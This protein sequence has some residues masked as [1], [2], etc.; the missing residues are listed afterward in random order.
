M[1]TVIRSSQECPMAHRYA[2]DVAAALGRDLHVHAV[3]QNGDAGEFAI[4]VNDVLILRRSIDTL[5]S[6]QEVETAVQ[7]ALVLKA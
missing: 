4:F 1:N 7:I 3:I 5:P 2:L 6:V